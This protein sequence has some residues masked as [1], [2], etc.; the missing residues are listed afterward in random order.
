MVFGTKCAT[1]RKRLDDKSE[2]DR[3]IL[4]IQRDALHEPNE[5]SEMVSSIFS[6]S[7][8]N[9]IDTAAKQRIKAPAQDKEKKS[10]APAGWKR[11]CAHDLLVAAVVFLEP[12]E[13][14]RKRIVFLN[15]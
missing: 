9:S 14:N 13:G 4:M 15:L 11:S 7:F 8:S 3:S 6:P 5:P 2:L 1:G 10:T 12:K